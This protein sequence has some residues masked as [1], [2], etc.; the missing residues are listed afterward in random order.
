[1]QTHFYIDLSVPLHTTITQMLQNKLEVC[2]CIPIRT[3]ILLRYLHS[4]I[5]DFK[6]RAWGA[7]VLL[8]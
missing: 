2:I 8:F 5:A 6:L 7:G 4:C 3:R 1:M